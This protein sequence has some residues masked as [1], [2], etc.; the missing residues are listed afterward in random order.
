MCAL[1]KDD[2]EKRGGQTWG[3]SLP[4]AGA[5]AYERLVFVI[6]EAQAALSRPSVVTCERALRRIEE[7][8]WDVL[9]LMPKLV[10]KQDMEDTFDDIRDELARRAKKRKVWC[11]DKTLVAKE[12]DERAK[13]FAESEK[14][15]R[16]GR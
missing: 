7:M 15:A 3:K 11:P 5:I 4:L 8:A 16:S 14:P 9:P 6:D 10:A 12:F 2:T 13:E 1:Q